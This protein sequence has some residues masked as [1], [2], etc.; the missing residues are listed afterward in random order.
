M[1]IKR[2][3]AGGGWRRAAALLMLAL[4]AAGCDD[5][6]DHEPPAGQGTIV[7]DNFT[8]WDLRV[9]LDGAEAAETDSGDHRAYDLAPGPYRVVLDA[10]DLDAAWA[11]D[12][13]VLEGRLTIL[14]VRDTGAGTARLD[15][16]MYFED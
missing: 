2:H 13:D 11:G 15:V 14:E 4:A 5:E 3:P 16:R 10:E 12:V 1:K 6:Y 9:Y 7:V 8:G